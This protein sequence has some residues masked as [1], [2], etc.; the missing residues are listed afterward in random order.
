MSEYQAEVGV[1]EGGG[2]T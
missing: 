2:S 1:F